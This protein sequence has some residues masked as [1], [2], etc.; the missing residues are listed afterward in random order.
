MKN[1]LANLFN[2]KAW[3]I[4]F[5]SLL[6]KSLVALPHPWRL[7]LGRQFG[8]LFYHINKKRRHIAKTNIA[9]CL[10]KY[11]PV[12]QQQVL[13]KH[14]ES[15]GMALI[16]TGMCWWESDTD[17]LNLTHFSGLHY[18]EEALEN[19][20]GAILLSAHF[21]PLEL[22]LRLLAAAITQP[23]Y[24]VYQAHTDPYLDKLILDNRLRHAGDVI[25]QNDIRK[26]LKTLKQNGIV[27]YAPDQSYRGKYSEIV[28]FFDI[29]ANSNTAT[30]RLSKI[31]QAPVLPFFVRRDN[32]SLQYHVEILPPLVNY[33]SQDTVQ[34]TLQYHRLIEAQVYKAPDQYLWIHRRFKKR[35]APYPDLYDKSL[36][37]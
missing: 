18:I 16:E 37:N 28:P 30:S 3:L 20:R 22:G 6:L 17:L 24:A 13:K 31:S 26:M 8:R 21:T 14:F 11:K 23:V 7:G 25:A 1:N 29:P 19:K 15:L 5:A 4:G 32:S 34:D 35:P 2:P 36:S 27:W 9:I 10:P 12:Q 33:P